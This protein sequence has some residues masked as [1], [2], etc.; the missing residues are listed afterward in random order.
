MFA[1]NL[2]CNRRDVFHTGTVRTG[3]KKALGSGADC[4]PGSEKAFEDM[5]ILLQHA[6]TR[7][8]LKGLGNWTANPYEAFDFQHSQRA[9]DYACAHGISG[10][11]IAVRFA[12]SDSDE[13]APLPAIG[14]AA[15]FQP[16]LQAVH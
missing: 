2:A 14:A 8:Y 11:Q 3:V 13:I 15:R 1:A 7:L 9:I 6:R 5:R 10:V 4:G 12:D 16:D